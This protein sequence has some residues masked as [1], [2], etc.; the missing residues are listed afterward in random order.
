MSQ[1]KT[2]THSHHLHPSSSIYTHTHTH[3]LPPQDPLLRE[4]DGLLWLQYTSSQTSG[5]NA[6]CKSYHQKLPVRVFRSSELNCRYAPTALATERSVD[7]DGTAPLYRYDGLY[8]VGAMW[9]ASGKETDEFPSASASN[10]K[11]GGGKG[12]QHTFLLTRLPKR[13]L[14]RLDDS[15]ITRTD[16]DLGRPHY[17]RMGIQELWREIQKRKGS[18]L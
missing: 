8:V 13:P 12:S 14:L 4:S 17:N 9:D 16:V 6:L 3:Q 1:G 5:G 10:D 18:N 11:K 15:T 2:H 7:D